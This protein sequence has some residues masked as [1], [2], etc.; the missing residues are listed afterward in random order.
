MNYNNILELMVTKGYI[1]KENED[2]YLYAMKI[3]VQGVINILALFVTG[4]LLGMLKE[5]IFMFLSFFVLRKFSGGLHADKYITC[6][7]SSLFIS[8]VGLI[9]IENHWFV[10]KNAFFV[11]MLI[12]NFL[13]IALSPIEHPNKK[14]LDKERKIYKL[15]ATVF[16]VTITSIS[17]LLVFNESYIEV[18]YSLGTGL[19]TSSLLMIVG[20]LI[21]QRFF[22]KGKIK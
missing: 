13:I 11:I 2:L 21:Y 1:S 20:N 22:M 9:L 8:V 5:S 3:S 18:G 15:I 16:S 7:I 12:L 14:I 17:F 10:S 6:L 4:L 19:M